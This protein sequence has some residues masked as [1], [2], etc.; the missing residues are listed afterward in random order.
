MAAPEGLEQLPAEP[1]AGLL[2]VP[3]EGHGGAREVPARSEQRQEVLLEDAGGG[4]E[5]EA[6]LAGWQDQEQWRQGS[7]GTAGALTP[8]QPGSGAADAS[9]AGL[10]TVLAARP[11]HLP[12]YSP[13]PSKASPGIASVAGAPPSAR[14]VSKLPRGTPER[15]SV[16]L[17]NLPANA[18]PR[19]SARFELLEKVT[20]A[21]QALMEDLG[22]VRK[23]VEAQ[24]LHQRDIEHIA[25]E[26]MRFLPE[27]MNRILEMRQRMHDTSFDMDTLEAKVRE[28]LQKNSSLE[29]QE[30][31][32]QAELELAQKRCIDA[33]T[34]ND[35]LRSD[36]AAT[37]TRAA[38]LAACLATEQAQCQAERA[39]AEQAQ[40]E[41]QRAAAEQAASL[42]RQL[43]EVKEQAA[44]AE[45][46]AAAAERLAQDQAAA[47]SQREA[48]QQRAIDELTA[49]IRRLQDQKQALTE[50]LAHQAASAAASAAANEEVSQRA[51]E[52]AQ[53]LAQAQQLQA[54]HG[55]QLAAAQEQVAAARQ[56]CS[57]AEEQRAAVQRNLAEGLQRNGDLSSELRQQRSVRAADAAAHQALTA[58]Q[59]GLAQRGEALEAALAQVAEARQGHA[60][61]MRQPPARS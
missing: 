20:A 25:P 47:A 5:A 23:A 9:L 2:M 18:T 41:A 26:L 61:Q 40:C 16:G 38:E 39:A 28:Q 36:L 1:V 6:S 4:L 12:S 56:E 13:V 51:A 50:Q 33:E 32:L 17:E 55:A 19:T 44:G 8:L 57:A 46:Q 53:E 10:P 30:S 31:R 54:Q 42:R 60:R 37:S 35:V 21:H 22:A 29:A 48:E 58:A 7:G 11:F 3:G 43:A 15:R 49:S 14:S 34:K 52:L 27:Q 59:A 24:Q 45:Q